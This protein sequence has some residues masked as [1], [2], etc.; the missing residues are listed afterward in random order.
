MKT[1]TWKTEV[2]EGGREEKDDPCS[3][4]VVS[5]G[6]HEQ[7]TTLK[8]GLLNPLAARETEIETRGRCTERRTQTQLY[9]AE[10]GDGLSLPH[11]TS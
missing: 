8:K 10:R 4:C 2:G 9:H 11:F 7:L 6:Q 3:P 5:D 1:P